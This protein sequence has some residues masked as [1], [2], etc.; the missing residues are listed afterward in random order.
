MGVV[1]RTTQNLRVVQVRAEDGVLLISGAVPG[2]NGSQ[3]IIRPA[4][5]KSAA[6]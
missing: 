5:K 6:K 1:R 4:K 3:V 2:A